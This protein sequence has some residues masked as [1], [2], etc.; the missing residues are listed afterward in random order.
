MSEWLREN[1][2]WL[3]GVGAGVAAI[4]VAAYLLWG[5]PRVVLSAYGERNDLLAPH[6]YDWYFDGS[7]NVSVPTTP[8]SSI[9][10]TVV[11]MVNYPT[12]KQG[13]SGIVDLGRDWLVNSWVLTHA[14]VEDVVFGVAFTDGSISEMYI[15]SSNYVNKFVQ[16]THVV[17]QDHHEAWYNTSLAQSQ[18]YSN[19]L[20]LNSSYGVYIASRKSDAYTR[21][22]NS[23]VMII[24]G[25]GLGQSDI[26][27]LFS[28]KTITYSG[29]TL[30]LDPTFFNGSAYVDLS[31]NN[32]NGVPSGDVR[33]VWASQ[34]WVWRV[35]GRYSDNKLHVLL[36]MNVNYTIRSSSGAV[37]AQG[38]TTSITDVPLDY[39]G[40]LYIDIAQR[41]T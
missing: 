2:P 24:N 37:L 8:V 17:Y 25:R 33:R 20:R 10:Y 36:P 13:W 38:T 18:G 23:F 5:R 27:S 9:P 7:S 11:T 39:S 12:F 28:G 26:N 4:G 3:V 14:Y 1:W 34:K 29:M 30:F 32:N 35:V 31:G 22:F 40:Q 16:L 19:T 21:G 41:Q 6:L 15:P